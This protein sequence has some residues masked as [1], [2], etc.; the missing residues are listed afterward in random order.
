VTTI[1]DDNIG[2]VRAEA[3]QPASSGDLAGARSRRFWAWTS[4]AWLASVSVT[5]VVAAA[6]AVPVAIGGMALAAVCNA[7]AE[8]EPN[9]PAADKPETRRQ[10]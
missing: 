10:L 4:T 3:R 5:V 7:M 8:P 1:S 6:D 2:R 9:A